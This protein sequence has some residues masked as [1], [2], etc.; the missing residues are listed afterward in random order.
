MRMNQQKEFYQYL[1][2]EEKSSA[3]VEKYTRDVGSFL[4]FVDGKKLNKTLVL[5]YKQNLIE[6]YAPASVNSMLAA[7]NCYLEFINRSDCK[8]KQIKVQRQL[9]AYRKRQR[10]RSL[11]CQP[12]YTLR[13]W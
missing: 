13:S 7:I 10:S 5:E 4:C 9:F 1:I 8:V 3:T 11:P 6:A 12:E 2:E